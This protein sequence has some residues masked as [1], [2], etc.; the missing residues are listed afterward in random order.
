[1]AVQHS[2]LHVGHQ[3]YPYLQWTKWFSFV[4]HDCRTTGT[5]FLL[6]TSQVT[7][8]QNNPDPT[9]TAHWSCEVITA[10]SQNIFSL[11]AL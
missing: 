6:V 9:G 8:L 5:F 11:E 10:A 1:M 4:A 3:T 2:H 7:V